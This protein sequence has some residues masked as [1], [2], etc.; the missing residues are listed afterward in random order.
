MVSGAKL[1]VFAHTPFVRRPDEALT[2]DFGAWV[3][4]RFWMLVRS[5]VWMLIWGT[6]PSGLPFALHIHCTFYPSK[7][8]P[9]CRS[10]VM[11]HSPYLVPG[12]ATMAVLTIVYLLFVF[13]VRRPGRKEDLAKRELSEL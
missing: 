4:G 3:H 6:E 11:S 1:I 13:W 9:S 2:A 5:F 10:C 8:L 7:N 12:A